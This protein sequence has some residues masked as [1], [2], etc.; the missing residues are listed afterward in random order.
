MPAISKI[1]FANVVYENGAKRYNDEVFYF[2]GH[3]AAILL[4]NGGGKTVFIQTALQA[5]IPHTNLADRKLLQTLSLGSA[6]AHIAIE[7]I[8]QDKP[9]QYAVTAV[10]LFLRND[11]LDS[12]KYVYMYP[13][14]DA[15]SLE[16]IPFSVLDANQKA[17][18]ASASEMNDYYVA[19]SRKNLMA[20]TF[21]TITDYRDF[22]EQRLKIVADEWDSLAV[23][24]SGEGDVESF[25]EHCKTTSDLV[26]R[27]LIP[28]VQKAIGGEAGGFAESFEKNRDQFRKNKQLK[29]QIEENKAIESELAGMMSQMERMDQVER[30]LALHKQTVKAHYQALST[31]RSE[32]EQAW[33]DAQLRLN[34]IAD[35]ELVLKQEKDSLNIAEYTEQ[36]KLRTLQL[37]NARTAYDTVHSERVEQEQTLLELRYMRDRQDYDR[38]TAQLQAE[39][40]KLQSMDEED[41]AEGWKE[42]L[43]QVMGQLKHLYEGKER[44]LTREYE[45]VKRQIDNTNDQNCKL[46]TALDNKRAEL[47]SIDK[48]IVRLTTLS[49]SLTKQKERIALDILDLP[50]EQQVDSEVVKW[51][52]RLLGTEQCIAEQEALEQQKTKEKDEILQLL[53]VLREDI[54]T[55]ELSQQRSADFVKLAMEEQ[56]RLLD[57]LRSLYALRNCSNVYLEQGKIESVLEL[58]D[59]KKIKTLE[60]AKLK[61]RISSRLQDTYGGLE[62]FVADP[63][64]C[65]WIQASDRPVESGSDF[66]RRLVEEGIIAKDELF[67]RFPFWP[68]TLVVQPEDKIWVEQK[69]QESS[70]DS[71]F[72]LIVLS[73]H[74]ARMFVE[75][76]YVLSTVIPSYWSEVLEVEGFAKWKH[77]IG[78]EA[79]SAVEAVRQRESERNRV[80]QLI[81]HLAQY[82]ERYPSEEFTRNVNE[83]KKSEEA[84]LRYRDDHESLSGSLKETEKRIQTLA[85]TKNTLR[86][87]TQKL[88][89]KINRAAEWEV[90]DVE[91]KTIVPQLDGCRKELHAL[92]RDEDRLKN[93][94]Q[95]LARILEELEGER[96]AMSELL[97]ELRGEELYREL[98]AF[99]GYIQAVDSEETLIQQ[100][101]FIKDQLLKVEKDRQAVERLIRQY[102]GEAD[103]LQI[104]L[105]EYPLPHPEGKFPPDGPVRIQQAMAKL[106]ELQGIENVKQISLNEAQLHQNTAETKLSTAIDAYTAY[107]VPI[108][109][110]EMPLDLVRQHLQDKEERLGLERE[111]FQQQE[112][113]LSTELSMLGK[114][115]NTLDKHNIKYDFLSDRIAQRDLSGQEILEMIDKDRL[116]TQS[117]QTL[118]RVHKRAEIELNS[119]QHARRNFER[120]VE[121]KVKNEKLRQAALNGIHQRKTYPEM[122]EWEHALKEGI[123]RATM[124]AEQGMQEFSKDLKHFIRQLT[125]YM[126]TLCDELSNI[127]KMTRVRV[128][129]TYK[130]IIV[131][132][133]PVW[134]EEQAKERLFRHVE[135]MSERLAGNEYTTDDGTE[136][137]AKV[138][139]DIERWLHPKQLLMK[140]SDLPI[141][142]QV[143][144]VSNDNRVSHA[145]EDWSS[146]N[147][148]SGGEKW[149]KNMALFLGI[150]SY[151]SEK[152]QHVAKSKANNR[153]AIL[154]NPFG[155]ASSDHVLEPVFFIANQL[156]YQIIALTAHTEGKFLRDYFPIIY[157]CRLRNA[158]S[159]GTAI[160]KHDQ[161]IRHA[162]FED[163]EPMVLDRLGMVEKIEQMDLF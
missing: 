47:A 10:T 140:I 96:V 146:S 12:H 79:Q 53:E 110:F 87:E 61:E 92:Q 152:R 66:A 120:F 59:D 150:Q 130:S 131:I 82:L 98:K 83:H 126:K 129:D 19:M 23:I 163:K 160:L 42:K 141:K 88:K 85:D 65:Q 93:E 48:Q 138:R 84:L 29:V 149:S 102:Q 80:V 63:W 162:Y 78:L 5:V 11:K 155:K 2:D 20:R 124:I 25:F 27:L 143:R 73:T 70:S 122:R 158:K 153:S 51:K 97:S 38:K 68:M 133:A 135:W 50:S 43:Q 44:Y 95:S 94:K 22:L 137:T 34:Q 103:Q 156:G 134:E 91:W 104:K 39:Q 49:Q 151:L 71:T 132:S 55:T 8:I 121:A 33:N 60:A 115:L 58:E 119:V 109:P 159:G 56:Q 90:C 147:L 30:E 13:P 62:T 139:R 6:H 15:G 54:R 75:E 52:Q 161:E 111:A 16:K 105:R 128:D 4:E 123:S 118:E 31:Q 26:N 32:V 125:V 89:D 101:M 35:S 18:P 76:P 148:W 99:N 154:D 81:N 17:R 21:P 77:Q 107:G 86:A 14:N 36:N 24:N 7:W 3:N 72:P 108:H 41:D 113:R 67:A 74:E 100:R 28:T 37:R 64:I 116:L 144:K 136:D 69:I 40:D 57:E 45:A 9:R 46:Q 145:L 117:L 112:Q 157:S 106:N 114:W 1:R 142:V 127:E